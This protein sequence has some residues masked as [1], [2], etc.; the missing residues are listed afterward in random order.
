MVLS[1]VN[2]PLR[3]CIACRR[4]EEQS[5]LIRIARNSDGILGL[6]IG[7]G[8]SAYV[9]PAPD[10]AEMA[11][12]KGRLERALRGPVSNSEREVLRKVLECKLR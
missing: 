3:T 2:P 4:K 8:R 11:L 1:T 7:S 12:A 5:A 9:H 10:C 6:W